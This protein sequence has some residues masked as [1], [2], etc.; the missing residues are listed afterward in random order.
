[1]HWAR[2]GPGLSSPGSS[3]CLM[4]HSDWLTGRRIPRDIPRWPARGSSLETDII[5]AARARQPW[6]WAGMACH[7]AFHQG[8]HFP[9]SFP[10]EKIGPEVRPLA[11]HGEELLCITN[12]NPRN[13]SREP[14]ILLGP[15]GHIPLTVLITSL[16]TKHSIV[17]S[18]ATRSAS[19]TECAV[20]SPRAP[21]T[22]Q[23]RKYGT[24]GTPLVPGCL[25]ERTRGT[26]GH[27]IQPL[28][29]EAS[30]LCRMVVFLDL[31]A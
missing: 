16:P 24:Y 6:L 2:P 12:S 30:G 28:G 4:R 8:Q 3:C 29:V 21:H 26:T 22:P 18:P 27:I 31:L 17:V 10:Q 14:S 9:K 7:R 23:L 5:R 20:F 19:R 15:D 1:M 25:P 13:R 11:R